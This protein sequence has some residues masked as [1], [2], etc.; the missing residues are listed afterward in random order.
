MT[1]L[2]TG[3]P[4]APDLETLGERYRTFATELGSSPSTDAYRHVLHD[5]NELRRELRTWSALTQLRFDQQTSDASARAARER[6]DEMWPKITAFD[7]AMKGRFTSSDARIALE[8]LTGP[9]AARLWE[10]DLVAFD[11]AIEADLVAES[12]AAA[13]YTAVLAGLTVEFNGETL[14]LAALT[15]YATHPDRSVRH[16]AAAARWNAMASC[17]EEFDRIFDELVQL[18]TRMARKLGFRSFTELGYKRMRRIGYGPS[19]VDR[20]RDTI[21]EHVVPL[22]AA[23]ADRAAKRMG[24]EA[25]ALWDEKFLTGPD[26]GA[27]LGDDAW[28]MERTI[29]SLGELHPDLGAFAQMMQ[30][31]GLTDLMTR[32]GKASGAHCTFLHSYDVPFVFSNFVGT[33]DDVRTLMHEL[34]HAYQGYRSRDL[35]VIDYV[36]PTLEAA[37]IHS[38]SLEFLT[39]PSM[40]RFFGNDAQIYRDAHLAESLAFLPYGVAVDHFQHLVYERPEATPAERHAMWQQ[41]E[42]RYLPWRTYG[43][44]DRPARGG[45]WQGQLHIYKAPFYYIDY[46]LALACAMQFWSATYDDREDAITRYV[47]LCARG[48]SASFGELVTSAQLHS[49]FVPG[50]LTKTVGR[51]RAMLAL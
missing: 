27:R 19:D 39:W 45:F 50:A 20:W 22:A 51:A 48:G 7:H 40:E 4:N 8:P 44:L 17:G 42:R 33:R 10:T 21:A 2:P 24:L 11:E 23:L 3:I 28:L 6:R 13:E 49:P 1:A 18:R 9:Q 30:Q 15:K 14:N 5:W 26:G 47:E 41:M 25:L 16:A 34:G 31:R 32:Q 37:E 46:T 35:P 36:T 38:M 29:A 43:D 12:R